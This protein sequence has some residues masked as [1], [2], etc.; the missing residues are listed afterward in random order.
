MIIEKEG[1]EPPIPEFVDDY[2]TEVT[3]RNIHEKDQS[4]YKKTKKEIQQIKLES[5]DDNL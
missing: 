5:D 4:I 3:Q 1:I 2:T